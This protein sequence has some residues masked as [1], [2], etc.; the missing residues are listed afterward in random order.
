MELTAQFVR[1][2]GDLGSLRDMLLERNRRAKLPRGTSKALVQATQALSR[3]V[4]QRGDLG[5]GRSLEG[6]ITIREPADGSIASK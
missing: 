4:R 3:L 1:A 6:G 2:N 5:P